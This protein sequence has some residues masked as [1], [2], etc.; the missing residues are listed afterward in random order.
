V[1]AY[2][3]S[4]CDES[5]DVEIMDQLVDELSPGSRDVLPGWQL[6]VMV[7]AN[8]ECD[9]PEAAIRH[10]IPCL[11]IPRV[12]PAVEANLDGYITA[13]HDIE[14]SARVGRVHSQ[15]LLAKSRYTRVH[16]G[17]DQVD[18]CIGGCTDDNSVDA[19]QK[20]LCTQD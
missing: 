12:E 6:M 7:L 14:R 20:L 13:G 3:L 19:L 18:V 11:A 8:H 10:K 5:Q 1:D 15:W 4:P 17:L 2:D 16:G 9:V